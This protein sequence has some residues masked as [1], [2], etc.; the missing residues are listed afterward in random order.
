MQTFGINSDLMPRMTNSRKWY[1]TFTRDSEHKNRYVIVNGNYDDSKKLMLE[2]YKHVA[3]Q[4]HEGE[5]KYYNL[6]WKL[7]LLKMLR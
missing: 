2:K 5:F 1:F 4:Y 7:R 6:V 3:G